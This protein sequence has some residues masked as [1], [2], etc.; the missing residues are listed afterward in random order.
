[1]A[2]TNLLPNEISATNATGAVVLPIEISDVNE[3]IEAA[4][5]DFLL[6]LPSFDDETDVLG[7]GAALPAVNA[8]QAMT[9]DRASEVVINPLAQLINPA[10]VTAF[11]AP[12]GDGNGSAR[13]PSSSS[14]TPPSSA[15]PAQRPAPAP[16][17]AQRPARGPS[18]A[19]L[20][21]ASAPHNGKASTLE[22]NREAQRRFRERPP[23][24]RFW[25]RAKRRSGRGRR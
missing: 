11:A 19:S 5:D 17:P 10:A 23:W 16:A 3:D 6:Q 25:R 4:L 20:Q 7:G 9:V 15:A 1:M 18:L 22:R 21:G 8:P 24:P 2:A 14:P 12:A 13:R